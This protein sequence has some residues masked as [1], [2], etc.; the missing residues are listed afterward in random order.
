MYEKYHELFIE[1][2]DNSADFTL[3]ETD[4]P[5]GGM[6]PTDVY[7]KVCKQIL[8]N[9]RL[10]YNKDIDV[11][12]DIMERC[13]ILNNCIY[14]EINQHS[15]P[16]KIIDTIFNVSYEK[17]IGFYD[18]NRICSYSSNFKDIYKDDRIILL[19]NFANNIE[20]IITILTNK[21]NDNYCSCRIFVND[22][23]NIY[24]N[25]K[26]IYC[27]PTKDRQPN[28][29]GTCEIITQFDTLYTGY[30]YNRIGKDKKFPILY[31]TTDTILDTDGCPLYTEEQSPSIQG[32]Q[33]DS[34]TA[35][36]LTTSVAAMA[37]ISSALTLLYKFTPAGKLINHRLR[38]SG[39]RISNFEYVDGA[40]DLLLDTPG[41]NVFNSYN[42]G[43]EAA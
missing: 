24:R 18:Q 1:N 15:I 9:L 26:Q 29:K 13:K 30:F 17:I 21:N 4:K 38:G 7:K 25:I 8:K 20:N 28:N 43:Y 22:C 35:H 32:N 14:K 36:K 10:L 33:S 41:N 5:Y 34:S 3:C 11:D 23:V 19:S 39:G 40:N 31:S 6:M 2:D 27:S 42:I 37:G 16:D 12:I